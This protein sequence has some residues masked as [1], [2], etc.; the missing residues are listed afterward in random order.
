MSDEYRPAFLVYETPATGGTIIHSVH[1]NREAAFNRCEELKRLGLANVWMR[2][3]RLDEISM[4]PHCCPDFSG[5]RWRIEELQEQVQEL[6]HDLKVKDRDLDE[7]RKVRDAL[8]EQLDIARTEATDLAN[9]RDRER[10][11]AEA[12][13]IG[14]RMAIDAMV[15]GMKGGK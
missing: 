6:S 7:L 14:F 8:K 9:F 11:H 2:E 15:N 10:K 1:T 3:M 12:V 5:Q 4:N 13:F